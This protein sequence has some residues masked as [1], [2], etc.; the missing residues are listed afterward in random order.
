[1]YSLYH[2]CYGICSAVLSQCRYVTEAAQ[3]SLVR[4]LLFSTMCFLHR[5]SL[6]LYTLCIS[7][8]FYR[9]CYSFHSSY[10]EIRDALFYLKP[11]RACPNVIPRYED[12]V[13]SNRVSFVALFAQHVVILITEFFVKKNV[14]PEAYS[15]DP[16]L[17][18]PFESEKQT[19]LTKRDQL[20]TRKKRV[21]QA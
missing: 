9:V 18:G 14:W 10:S 15:G 11:K 17:L 1:M 7:D 8:T 13:D 5:V 20:I 2:S 3:Q 12:K 4:T 16:L 6:D 19:F 21:D